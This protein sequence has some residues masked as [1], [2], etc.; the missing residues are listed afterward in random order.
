MCAA[1]KNNQ[2]WKLRAKH[3]RDK[4]FSSPQLLW[5][6][7]CEYFQWCVDNPLMEAEQAK[8]AAKPYYDEEKKE[9][10]F[11]P[12][13]VELPKMR[14]F[15]W[16]GLE[17]YIDI[18]SLRDY[19]TNPDYKDFQQ[20]ITRIEKVIYNQ[21]FT[22]AAA[23]FLN[24]NIIARDLGLKDS[25]DVTTGGEKLTGFTIEIVEPDEPTT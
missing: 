6:A 15:T 12:N 20:V 11:P 17:L 7:A 3:G 9:T 18:Y 21:K 8:S 19:K 13:L 23:G 4:L 24:P 22:G 1:P 14:A 5:E 10:V 16:D 25:T 2:F